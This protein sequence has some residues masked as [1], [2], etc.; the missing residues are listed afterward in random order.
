[1]KVWWILFP[2]FLFVVLRIARLAMKGGREARTRSFNALFAIATTGFAGMSLEIILIFSF[3]NIF[4]YIYQ[5][6]GII[7]SIFM[8]GLSA[9]SLMTNRILLRG[10][11]EWIWFLLAIEIAICLFGFFLAEILR[12]FFIRASFPGESP[13]FFLVGIAGFFAGLEFPLVSRILIEDGL[14][15][16]D[17]AGKVDSLDHLGACIGGALTGT[18]FVPI[19]GTEASCSI[20]G[21]LKIASL[22]FIIFSLLNLNPIL[23]RP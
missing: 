9:G 3:Q 23:R 19:L 2:L 21:F 11:R 13:F 5:Q 16:G 12:D 6:I 8:V 10:D 1:V 22:I 17:V 14:E 7:V 20:V 18:L 15:T 4:G